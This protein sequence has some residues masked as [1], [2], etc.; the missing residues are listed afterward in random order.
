MVDL[1]HTRDFGAGDTPLGAVHATSKDVFDTGLLPRHV[2]L[3]YFF[4]SWKEETERDCRTR[5]TTVKKNAN[6]RE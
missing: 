6:M 3:G 5:Q 1:G 2:R 4:F